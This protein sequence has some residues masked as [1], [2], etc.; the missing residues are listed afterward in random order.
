MKL[1]RLPM[2]GVGRNNKK[3]DPVA[4]QEFVIATDIMGEPRAKTFTK[5]IDPAIDG[6]QGLKV[7]ER[8]EMYQD[9]KEKVISQWKDNVDIKMAQAKGAAFDLYKATLD[10]VHKDII[11]ADGGKELDDSINRVQKVLKISGF[12]NAPIMQQLEE[13]HQNYDSEGIII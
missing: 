7:L 13:P 1:R 5:L 4:V 9:I 12:G 2:A 3:F 8:S 10:K 6:K 11:D